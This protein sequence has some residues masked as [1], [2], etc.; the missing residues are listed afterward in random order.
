MGASRARNGSGHSS[1]VPAFNRAHSCFAFC[2]REPSPMA[3]N[4]DLTRLRRR[5]IAFLAAAVLLRPPR[6][7]ATPRALRRSGSLP[8]RY[9]RSRRPTYCATV[10]STRRP[11]MSAAD[12]SSRAAS[13]SRRLAP[14]WSKGWAS[15][16]VRT[17]SVWREASTRHCAGSDL[18]APPRPPGWCASA[19]F[20]HQQNCSPGSGGPPVQNRRR[21]FDQALCPLPPAFLR[22]PPILWG[23]CRMVCGNRGLVSCCF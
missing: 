7:T 3:S 22:P 15:M 8:S 21:L 20:R 5:S 11:S 2:V 17:L 13:G 6:P 1:T 10:G 19:R 14:S 16:R 4:A 23:M 9:V 18:V 12:T